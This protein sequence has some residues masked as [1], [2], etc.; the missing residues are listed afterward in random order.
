MRTID[1]R[2]YPPV[3]GTDLEQSLNYIALEDVTE[4][5][6]NDRYT[7]A[8]LPYTPGSRPA[9]EELAKRL[10]KGAKTPLA[11]VERL[12][13]F[14]ANEVKWAG[15]YQQ[16]TGRRLPAGRDMTEE[17]LIVS[18]NAWC[19]EQARVLCALTQ[20]LGIP[21]RMV[22]GANLKKRYGHVVTEVLLPEGWML[23]DE[24]LG[25]CFRLKGRPVCASRIWNDPKTR[26]AFRPIYK[27][28]CADLIGVLGLKVLKGSFDMALGPDPLDGFSYIGYHNHFIL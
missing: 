9:L 1:K 21:S 6:I 20:V 17:E 10:A 16:A 11:K 24:S 8:R 19:N 23:V 18:G 2:F 13:A 28:L 12:T 5:F 4:S 26:A 3:K 7:G 14:V 22:F 25:Y 15:F 27:K